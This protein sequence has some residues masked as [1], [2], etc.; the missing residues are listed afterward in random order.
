VHFTSDLG[1]LDKAM[2]TVR[3][4]IPVVAS[5]LIAVA[6]LS[7]GAS[8]QGIQSAADGPREGEE[9]KGDTGVA[10]I[11][12]VERGFYLSV[13]AGVNH[14]WY[15]NTDGFVKLGRPL[16]GEPANPTTWFSPG[17]RMGMRAG[18][19]IL[20]NINAELFVLANFNEGEILQSDI[21]SGQLTGD[22]SHLVAGVGARFAFLTL[23]TDYPRFFVYGRAGAGYGLWFPSALAQDSIGS[24]H[25]DG[26]LGV[27][28]YT[29]L[30]HLSVGLEATFQALL[31]PMAFG[32]QVYP[33]VKYTF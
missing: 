30:R 19:D 22:L 16:F 28:Y 20:N 32:V 10:E 31:L 23:P 9:I 26:S 1:Y 33:T 25:V 8:A 4:P 3:T 21:A 12:E 14:Y 5:A 29:K 27:E 24:I 7:P 2:R 13:D 18:Y 11:N 17:T 6:L 15:M